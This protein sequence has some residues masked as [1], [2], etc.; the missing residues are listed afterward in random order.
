M[1]VFVI[2]DSPL[3][4]RRLE[5]MLTDIPGL[6]MVG[7]MD[8]IAGTVEAIQAAK[9]DLVILDIQFPDGSGIDILE[10]LKSSE[11]SMVKIMLTEFPNSLYRQRCLDAGAHYFL[12]KTMEFERVV[13]VINSLAIQQSESINE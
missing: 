9:P 3:V 10:Q 8:R 2:D 7:Q 4:R 11:L 1:R 13:E 5:Q 12:D 6:C